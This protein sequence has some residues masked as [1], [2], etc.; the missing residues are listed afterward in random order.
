MALLV[1]AGCDTTDPSIHADEL[2]VEAYLVAGEALPPVWLS[3]SLEVDGT[4][5]SDQRAV[6][7]ADLRIERLDAEGRVL[8][9][10]P[11][12]RTIAAL[13]QFV[14]V[15]PH[16]VSPGSTYRLVALADGLEEA[17]AITRV[18]EQFELLEVSHAALD[19]LDPEQFSFLVT[20]SSFEDRQSIFVFTIASRDPEPANLVPPYLEFFFDK[21]ERESGEPLV[22]EPGEQEELARFTSPPIN[23]GNYDLVDGGLLRVRLPWFAVA[24]YGPTDITMSVLDDNLYDFQRY[25]QSQQNGGLLSPGEI[26]NVPDPVEGGAGIF[27]SMARVSSVV[28]IRRPAGN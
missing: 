19:Y 1:L 27:G 12:E 18:P 9:T 28:D 6:Q 21:E 16:T 13:G 7:Q 24:F 15:V 11:Y 23:E 3:R 4:W 25:Q 5:D 8:E 26:P 10:F 22:F 17:R 20:R 14:P 2:V